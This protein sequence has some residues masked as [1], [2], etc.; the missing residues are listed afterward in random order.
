TGDEVLKAV[1]TA[2]QR[3]VG[4]SDLVIRY[5]GDEFLIVLLEPTQPLDAARQ[6]LTASVAAWNET[7][8]I[9]PFPITLSIGTAQ[10]QPGSELPIEVVLAQADRSMY[11]AK[12][13]AGADPVAA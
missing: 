8:D 9:V 13:L 4:A 2:M 1:A 7:Q 10:W 5:G 11:A 3:A 6:S 12:R